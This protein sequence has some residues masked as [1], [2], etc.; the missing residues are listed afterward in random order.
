MR[1]SVAL[2]SV[3]FA[4]S[5]TALPLNATSNVPNIT[6]PTGMYL[7]DNQAILPILARRQDIDF[8]LVDEA[9][10]PTVAIDDSSNYNQQAAIDAVVSEV[11][12][13]PLPQRRN[14]DLHRRDIVVETSSG[15]TPNIQIQDAA[16]S[17]PKNCQGSDTFLGSKLFATGPFDTTLCAA[18]CTAQSEYNVRHP[19]AVGVARTCQFYNTYAMYRNGVYQGQYCAMYTQAWDASYAKNDGQWR[20]SV[21][22][23][24]GLSYIASN[25]T[26]SGDVS[27]PSD[28]P[29]LSE[30]GAGFCTAFID[31]TPPTSTVSTV[32]V[33]PAVSVLTSTQSDFVTNIIYSTQLTTDVQTATVTRNMKRDVQTPASLST[34]SPSRISAACSSVA[35]GTETVTATKTAVTPLSTTF[36]TQIITQTQIISTTIVIKSTTTKSV[37]PVA[38]PIK[39]LNIVQNPS[40]ENG[41]NYWSVQY[42]NGWSFASNGYAATYAG[43]AQ[44]GSSYAVYHVQSGTP[45]DWVQTLTGLS[46]TAAYHL[47]F[48]TWTGLNGN[49]CSMQVILGSNVLLNVALSNSR[50]GGSSGYDKRDVDVYPTAY[51]EQLRFRL[52]CSG[53]S[54]AN[55]FLDNVSFYAV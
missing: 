18:A 32:T 20:G 15:Y 25:A 45:I 3:A 5:V 9:P 7:A 35:T 28:V 29:Y 27:C 22:Y 36:T 42:P 41:Q 6:I 24:M 39:G 34:W 55:M 16:I 33:T 44:S 17:A 30:N 48:Y 23:T 46:N 50:G 51:S 1:I 21:H 47:T 26:Q 49:T 37:D 40:F 31:Y 2:N 10:E 43:A 19:P 54:V 11:E 8:D 38:T 4:L 13:N 53:G 52:T 14:T 12:A